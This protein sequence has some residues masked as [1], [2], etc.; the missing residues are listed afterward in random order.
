MLLDAASPCVMTNNSHWC[1]GANKLVQYKAIT[2]AAHVASSGDAA[3]SAL[4]NHSSAAADASGATTGSDGLR[5]MAGF[6][7]RECG[8]TASG[9]HLLGARDHSID[10]ARDR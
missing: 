3:G 4:R 5:T 1:A 2:A 7:F 10:G 6:K 8:R 9:F